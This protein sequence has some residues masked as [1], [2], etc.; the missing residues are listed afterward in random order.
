MSILIP[1]GFVTMREAADQVAVAMYGG[2]PDRPVVKQNRD[3]GF[4]VSDRAAIEYAIAKIWAAVDRG[5][6]EA[7]VFGPRSEKPLRL[8]P[9]VSKEIPALRSARGGSFSFLRFGN[10]HYDQFHNLFGANLAKVL[11][12]FEEPDIKKLARSLL[13][14]RRRRTARVAGKGSGRPS[15][16]SEIGSIIQK[17][18]DG[19][20]WNPTSSIKA[21]TAIVNRQLFNHVSTE[22]VT[23][24]LDKL[25]S[26][27]GDRRFERLRQA[28]RRPSA[29][30]A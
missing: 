3:A 22:T 25:Y 7:F 5:R 18:I 15:R 23:R 12:I 14:T 16:Q 11:V 6:L 29:E 1:I 2:E 8:S 9:S 4:D 30:P 24:A 10:S 13:L 17:A 19:R 26:Q 28:K 20:K 27:T 21:L